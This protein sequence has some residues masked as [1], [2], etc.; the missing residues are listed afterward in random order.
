[1]E[2]IP[3]YTHPTL[4]YAEG[5]WGGGGEAGGGEG[6]L[7]SFHLTLESHD[8]TEEPMLHPTTMAWATFTPACLDLGKDEA[9]HSLFYLFIHMLFQSTAENK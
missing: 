3:T 4:G 8:L 9:S 7:G 5:Y 1:M 2:L 6:A